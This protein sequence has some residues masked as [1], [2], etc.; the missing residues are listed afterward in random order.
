MQEIQTFLEVVQPYSRAVKVHCFW[1][2]QCAT[3]TP[4]PS[5]SKRCERFRRVP[6]RGEGNAAVSQWGRRPPIHSPNRKH[7][8]SWFRVRNGINNSN[9]KKIKSSETKPGELEKTKSWLTKKIILK[10][11]MKMQ[12]GF[13]LRRSEV[14]GIRLCIPRCAPQQCGPNWHNS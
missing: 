4:A 9:K 2:H 12:L 6:C 5:L 8:G 14:S 10:V 3:H 1:T 7:R 13:P 11:L